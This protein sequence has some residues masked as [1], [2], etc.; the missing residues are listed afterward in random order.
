M[1]VSLSSGKYQSRDTNNTFLLYSTGHKPNGGEI[2]ASGQAILPA[3]QT[4]C[5]YDKRIK[6]THARQLAVADV[7]YS[8]IQTFYWYDKPSF[9]ENEP[10]LEFWDKIPTAWDETK[11]L[12]GEPGQFITIA[13]RKGKDW[14]IGTLTNNDARTVKISFD[15][16]PKGKKYI[17]KIYSDD[18]SV[19]TKTKVNVA[20]RKVDASVVLGVTL[21]ASGG[22]AIWIRPE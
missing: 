7:Y 21:M 13:R 20:E 19:N 1:L 5:Y 16:L 22:Q 12:Q 4:I 2:D 18:P 3:K 17:A 11:V 8:P 14:F 15:F 10:E 9:S 6:T